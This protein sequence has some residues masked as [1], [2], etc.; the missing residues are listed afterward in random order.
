MNG[1]E[2]RLTKDDD[3]DVDRA[4]DAELVCFLKKTI[5]ALKKKRDK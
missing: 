4:K 1:N 5:F 2:E 3:G